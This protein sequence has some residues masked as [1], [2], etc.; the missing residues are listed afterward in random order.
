MRHFATVD[1]PIGLLYAVE[2]DGALVYLG[3]PEEMP[4]GGEALETPLLARLRGELAEYFSGERRA[5]D[6]PLSFAGAP[7]R[8]KCW[9]GLMRIPYGQTLTY[10]QLAAYAG[11]PKAAR[12]AGG[13]CHANPILILIPC[14]R[15]VGAKGALTGFGAGLAAKA[16]LLRLESGG[17]AAS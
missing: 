3:R 2:E 9:E 1:T 16:L 15:V 6:I 12:A 11:N 10:A 8:A 14:H 17:E 13:A 4:A 5:F 7:W